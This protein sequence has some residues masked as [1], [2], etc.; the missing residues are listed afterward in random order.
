VPAA[1][2]ATSECICILVRFNEWD[3]SEVGMGIASG[4]S[5]AR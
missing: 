4:E 3:L 2:A 1:R 5:I